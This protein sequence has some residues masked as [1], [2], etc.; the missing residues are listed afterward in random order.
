MLILILPHQIILFLLQ[1]LLLRI[2][3]IE[4]LQFEVDSVESEHHCD[5]E[6][7]EDHVY[8]HGRYHLHRAVVIEVYVWVIAFKTIQIGLR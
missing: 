4:G 2:E 8:E 6:V 7:V 5:V 3:M 1:G